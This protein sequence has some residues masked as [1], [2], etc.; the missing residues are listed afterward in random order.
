ML[1]YV[2]FLFHSLKCH[3]DADLTSEDLRGPGHRHHCPRLLRESKLLFSVSRDRA[4]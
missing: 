2:G 1:G 3:F 4:E